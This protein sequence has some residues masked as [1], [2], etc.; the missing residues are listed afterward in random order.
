[1]HMR[2]CP[3]CVHYRKCEPWPNQRHLLYIAGLVVFC[4]VFLTFVDE[5]HGMVFALVSPCVFCPRRSSE[6]DGRLR[7]LFNGVVVS[8]FLGCWSPVRMLQEAC[9]GFV[10]LIVSSCWDM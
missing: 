10:I 9:R 8:L 7:V 4:F 5:C 6:I 3:L 1:M 2:A